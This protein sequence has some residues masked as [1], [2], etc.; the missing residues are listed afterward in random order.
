HEH[1]E[2]N[3]CA[4][5]APQAGAPAA[6]DAECEDDR[7]RLHELDARRE[8]GRR[9]GADARDVHGA[10]LRVLRITGPREDATRRQWA[11]HQSGA[12]LPPECTAR[13]LPGGAPCWSPAAPGNY[14]TPRHR[15]ALTGRP[16]TSGRSSR[17][18][19][20]IQ[21]RIRT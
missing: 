17:A 10:R 12:S 20:R 7:E 14:V 8:E 15:A 4:R 19:S 9:C 5:R 3:E 13:P 16:T 18:N 2:E 6:R 11:E 21:R 1:D